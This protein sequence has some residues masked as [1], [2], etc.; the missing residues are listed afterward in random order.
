[1]L[2][3]HARVDGLFPEALGTWRAGEKAGLIS[4]EFYASAGRY[5]FDRGFKLQLSPGPGPAALA[6]G[7][8]TRQPLPWGSGHHEEF[9]RLFDRIVG[10]TVCVEDLPDVGNRIGL[11]PDIQDSDGEA[12]PQIIYTLSDN[13]RRCLAF[14]LERSEE[15]LRIGGATTTFRDELRAQAGFHIVGNARMGTD[16]NA[17]VVDPWGRCHNVENLFVGDAS[18]FVTSGC[19]NPTSTAQAFALRLA[20]HLIATSERA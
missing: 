1:M 3:P 4:L 20:D 5:S 11:S 12:A 6:T 14:G 7:A 9:E 15:A 17:S 18:V 16:P 10:L 2:H 19:L 8:L 13:S